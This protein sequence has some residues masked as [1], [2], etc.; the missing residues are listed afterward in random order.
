MA[1][2]NEPAIMGRMP[3]WPWKGRHE[4]EVIIANCPSL[5]KGRENQTRKAKIVTTIAAQT[6]PQTRVVSRN[7]VSRRNRF[8]AVALLG[9]M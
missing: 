6:S 5:S 4:R 8:K 3:N 1:R 2:L 9:G 7:R